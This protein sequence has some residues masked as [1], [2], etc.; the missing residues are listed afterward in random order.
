MSKV[1]NIEDFIKPDQLACKIS[2]YFV[3]WDTS[4]QTWISEKKEVQSYIYATDTTKTANSRLPWSNTT[5]IPK[6]CQ[7][8]DNLASNYMASMFPKR[9]W[10][11]WEGNT[12]TDDDIS[13]KEAIES[14]MSWVID[15][16]EFYDEV[17]KLVLDYI[18]YGNA[19]A[20]PEWVDKRNLLEDGKQQVG[21]VGPML[22]RV[23]PMDIVFNPT[24]PSFLESP[25]IIRSLISLG[26]LKEML[27]RQSLDDNEKD[28]AKELYNYIKETRNYVSSYPGTAVV[29]DVIYQISGF[30]SFQSYLQSSYCEVLTF[31]GDI[32]DEGKD[33][34]L[35]NQVIKIVDR[36]KIISRNT[37][38][39]FFGSAPIYHAGWRVRPDNLWAM[40]PLDNLVGLQYRIDHLENMKADIWD[41]TR[42]PVFH[43]KGQVDDFTWGPGEHIVTDETGEV[44]M[45]APDVQAL[46]ANTEIA[47]LEQKM[48]E[49]AGSPKEAMGFRTPGEK[50]MYEVQRLELAAGRIFQN[51]IAQFERQM[52]EMCLNAMLELARRHMDPTT[53]R[54]FDTE[55]K[56]NTFQDLTPEDITGNGRLKPIAAR[57]FAEQATM[58][59]NLNNFFS[60]AAGQDPNVT[61][62][63]SGVKMAQLWETLLD[64]EEYD[65]VSP[66]VR[67]SEQADMQRFAN[68]GQEHA[69]TE[70][71]TPGGIL[72]GDHDASALTE[73]AQTNV[74]A[75]SVGQPSQVP[76]GQGEVPTGGYPQ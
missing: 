72:P 32:Y 62:H 68:V 6:L 12:K 11:V 36:H 44:N 50:T 16:N 38:P 74:A 66:Y 20:I 14:Y 73:G 26:E 21:Y 23:N 15:R 64:L 1:L 31:Y 24:A 8:R 42:F 65:V 69:N 67:I 29:K 9:K 53:I 70:T 13:K 47:I 61:I 75:N 5:T 4:R 40:G 37:N 17:T 28:D 46:Q 56:V 54:I 52:L 57:H 25:K 58:V 41:L 59:Q 35:R 51:K 18:D 7:I 22:R 63:F 48:E 39:S 55:F 19:I 76:G 2:E 34:F 30:D 10:L 49:M 27:D 33:E 60:S 43:I 71:M 45:I 3:Q